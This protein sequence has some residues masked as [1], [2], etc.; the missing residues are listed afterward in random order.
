MLRDHGF[1]YESFKLVP[2]AFESSGAWS[3]QGKELWKEL[4]AI[5]KA[6]HSENYIKQG[7]PHT[8]AAFTFQQMV[9]QRLSFEVNYWSARGS[10]EAIRRSR[11][12]NF[13]GAA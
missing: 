5:Y 9:P 10:I 6:L 1:N 2:F 3:A 8:H 7:L 12:A 13:A 4:V 11:A